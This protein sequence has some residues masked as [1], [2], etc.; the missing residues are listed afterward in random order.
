MNVITEP[1]VFCPLPHL[2]D[3]H[4]SNNQLTGIDFN[5]SCIPN[6]RFIDLEGNNIRGLS[7]EH[8]STLDNVQS[9]N[10]VFAVDLSNNPF[11]C[12]CNFGII[13]D[14]LRNTNVS[15]RNL[16]MT[17]CT[18]QVQQ[19]SPLDPFADYHNGCPSVQTTTKAGKHGHKLMM[20]FVSCAVFGFLGVVLYVSMF[21]LKRLRP[22]FTNA[23]SRKIHYT[24]I[25][26]CEDQ[27]IHV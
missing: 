21:G 23:I 11:P 3:L 25:D 2:L 5:I 19:K 26:K 27:E 20:L 15:V 13:D 12:D 17:R 24:T 4:L 16:E 6:L 14:W 18:T 7:N 1:H 10:R 9:R 8:L 22:E